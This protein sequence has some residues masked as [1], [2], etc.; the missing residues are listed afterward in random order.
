[1]GE[2]DLDQ[3]DV[4]D[5]LELL[6]QQGFGELTVKVSEHN[7]QQVDTLIRK[8]KVSRAIVTLKQA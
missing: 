1:M 3:R 2:R 6:L 7:I 8:R 4:L 5:A